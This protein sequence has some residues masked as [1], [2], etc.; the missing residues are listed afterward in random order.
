VRRQVLSI[1]LCLFLFSI[2]APAPTGRAKQT[3][4]VN[5]IDS[6]VTYSFGGQLIILANLNSTDRVK[7]AMIFLQTQKNQRAMHGNADIE[8]GDSL[9]QWHLTYTQDLTQHP[10]RAFANIKYWFGFL[11]E[12]GSVVTS[13]LFTFYYEDNRYAWQTLEAPP[14]RMHWYEG[15]M[16]LGQE[17]FNTAWDGLTRAK[18][19]LSLEPPKEVNIFAY[20]SA[21]EVQSTIRMGGMDWAAGNTD[22]SL[23]VILVSLPPGPEQRLEMARQIP[24]ELMHILI[25][26]KVG[27]RYHKLP[28]WLVEGLASNV[29]LYP[30]PDYALLLQTA[31]ERNTLPSLLSLCQTF[32]QDAS[33]ALLAYAVSTSFTQFLYQQFGTSGLEHL[34]QVYAD[35]QACQPGIETALGVT[36]TDL[37]HSWQQKTLESKPV[38]QE[39]DKLI[40]WLVIFLLILIIPLIIGIWSSRRSPHEMLI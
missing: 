27:E 16:R 7:E 8:K 11:L 5:V 35:G 10:L 24:H 15:N 4:D 25:Y 40:P 19:I 26:N 20:A 2:A 6:K 28:I 13:K 3:S 33:G 38:I 39:M 34:L 31:H 22:P 32:P 37:E 18:S 12:D 1:V 29:E 14:F 17:V 36:L 23:N 21:R 9:S 30:D